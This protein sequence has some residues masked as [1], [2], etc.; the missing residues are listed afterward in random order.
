MDA[1]GIE[2]LDKFENPENEPGDYSRVRIDVILL[3]K[4]LT[5]HDGD[6]VLLCIHRMC[7][8]WRSAFFDSFFTCF[9]ALFCHQ[10]FSQILISLFFNRNNKK[11][12]VLSRP[13]KCSFLISW[14]FTDESK[15]FDQK[16]FFYL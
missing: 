15:N 1:K 7:L 9:S 10:L 5:T 3:N 13:S 8:F 14:L 16:S 11:C 4:F 6:Q 12:R 2:I